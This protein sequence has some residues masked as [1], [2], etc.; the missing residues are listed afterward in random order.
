M[1]SLI[2]ANGPELSVGLR[3]TGNCEMTTK[4]SISEFNKRSGRLRASVTHT[5]NLKCT[6][7]RQEGIN[8]HWQSIHIEHG[9]FEKLVRAFSE[10]G[11]REVNLTG[12]DATL[13]PQIN[14]IVSSARAAGQYHLSISTNG[15]RLD[16]ALRSISR[17]DEVKLSFHSLKRDGSSAFLGA[18][19]NPQRVEKNILAA[20]EL[21][22]RVTINFTATNRNIDELPEILDK[23]ISWGADL[24]LIDLIDTKFR[25]PRA[26]LGQVSAGRLEA[27]IARVARLKATIS[28][29]SGCVMRQY[30]TPDGAS[31]YIKDVS[32]GLLH[33]A[34]C[35][36]CSVRRQSGCRFGPLCPTRPSR[37]LRR[38][39]IAPTGEHG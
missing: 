33:T 21:G 27:M 30:A 8:S 10:I 25:D 9:F 7:C 22:A 37:Q 26:Q 31:W 13:H 4:T 38:V 17:L 11:G 35:N 28:D 15:L 32:Y 23:V 19:W 29:R 1:T 39:R 2:G 20:R 12:G 36:G 3:F 6:F 24:R 5:C 16:R 34:M 14:E 18:A